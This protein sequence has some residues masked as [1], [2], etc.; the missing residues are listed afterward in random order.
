MNTEQR[1]EAVRKAI[2]R[3]AENA[4]P[5]PTNPELAKLAGYGS[6]SG[7]V[8]ALGI[9]VKRGVLTVERFA[10]ARRVTF[11]DGVAT[12]VVKG[13]PHW[14][15]IGPSAAGAKRRY[16]RMS[17]RQERHVETHQSKYAFAETLRVSRDP[18][19]FCAVRADIGCKHRRA[20]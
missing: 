17:T 1:I 7:P 3:A 20:A 6:I 16:E 5:C 14:R 8:G 2:R 9:L 15:D 10:T 18:C 19:P 11:A 13:T 12:A 4:L